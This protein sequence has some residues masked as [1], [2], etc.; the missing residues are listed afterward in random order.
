MPFKGDVVLAEFGPDRPHDWILTENLR[1]T[2]PSGDPT[3]LVE[4]GFDTDLASV[5]H[6]LTWYAPRYGVY[7][8]AAIVHDQL[9]RDREGDRFQADLIFRKGMEELGVPLIKRWV[10]WTAVTWGTIAAN[11][12]RGLPLTL[13]TAAAVVVGSLLISGNTELGTAAVASLT[14]AMSLIGVTAVCYLESA[15][16]PLWPTL[17]AGYLITIPSVLLVVA[18]IPLLAVLFLSGLLD[19]ITNPRRTLRSWRPWVVPLVKAV[20]ARFSS[21]QARR[22]VAAEMK[23]GSSR[24][25]RVANVVLA[26]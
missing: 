6:V 13:V 10:M 2:A 3:I 12:A 26:E 4:E 8:R 7:T 24:E 25:Q 22:E 5:P 11:L 1:Y 20:K 19:L 9:C 16:R 14:V 21:R 15:H 18:S 23:T 17:L